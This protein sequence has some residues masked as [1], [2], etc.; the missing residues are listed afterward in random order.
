MRGRSSVGKWTPTKPAGVYTI[1]LG[2]RRDSDSTAPVDAF[3]R[4][5]TTCCQKP[6]TLRY[7]SERL[8]TVGTR[9]HV[10][11]LTPRVFGSPGSDVTASRSPVHSKVRLKRLPPPVGR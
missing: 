11:R 5:S 9:S 2:A 6:T 1:T 4:F 3:T 8:S 10:Q 7:P